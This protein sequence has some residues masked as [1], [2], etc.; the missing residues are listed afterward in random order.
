MLW[1]A[2]TARG[3][4]RRL[5]AGA[6]L[7]SQRAL[8]HYLSIPNRPQSNGII[9]RFVRKVVE[10]ARSLLYQ[11]GLT[12]GWWPF[13]CM[14]FVTCYNAYSIRDSGYTPWFQR[15]EKDPEFQMYPFGALVL[16]RFP[17]KVD[18]S[19]L[20]KFGARLFPCILLNIGLNPGSTW[21]RSY[22]VVSLER[23]LSGNRGSRVAVRKVCDLVFPENITF[24][25]RQRRMLSA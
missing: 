3:S 11:S 15:H 1:W 13:A 16:V 17:Q 22:T 12:Q 2:V 25:L 9:E 6:R 10:G 7:R 20:D 14:S 5:A 21:S 19:S 8:A 24:P 23:L 4:A 18:G